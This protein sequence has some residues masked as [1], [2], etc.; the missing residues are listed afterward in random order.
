MECIPV[1][2]HI[3][4][5]GGIGLYGTT[6]R[7]PESGPAVLVT[8]ALHGDEV[9]STGA[10]WHLA[11]GLQ[12]QG[13]T[14]TVTLIPCVNQLAVRASSRLVP[15]EDTDLNR[16]FPGRNDG[17]LAERLAHG[18]VELLE[19]HDALVDVHTAGWC[20]SYVLVD[21]IP[22]PDLRDRVVSWAQESG[23]PVI[24]EMPAEHLALQ[25]LDRSFSA[26]G[27]IQMR[28]PA[29]T[30]ELPGFH[31]LESRQ[32]RSGAE[33]LLRLLQALPRL[34]EPGHETRPTLSRHETFASTG[35]LFEAEASLGQSLAAGDRIG[36]LHALDGTGARPVAADKPGILLA[37]QPIS[38]VHVGSW[39]ATVAVG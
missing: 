5:E 18:L 34:R 27:S 11:R 32:A 6:F 31:T 16:H 38:A 20:T 25:G 3:D 1:A 35:G 29:L 15:L 19:S 14:G 22:H 28:K 10:I 9:T 13:L 12:D 21:E 30:V 2:K 39:L 36:I 37:L 7:F 4:V 26:W 8:G 24:G 17:S 33:V 23:L